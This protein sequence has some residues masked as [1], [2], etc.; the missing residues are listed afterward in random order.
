MEE[1]IKV[2]SALPV[3]HSRRINCWMCGRNKTMSVTNM[4]KYYVGHCFG[5]KE[6]ISADPPP[7]TPQQRLALQR[8]AEAF[9]ASEPELPDDFTHDI[10]IEGLLWLSKGGLHVNDIERYGFGWSDELKRTVLPVWNSDG[11]LVAVQARNTGTAHGPKYLGQV[12]SGPRPV[13]SSEL[14]SGGSRE[15]YHSSGPV[16]QERRLV[17][18]E[19]ILSA[20][21]VGK[22]NPAWSLLGTNMLPAVI[23]QIDRSPFQEVAIWMDDDEAG[24]NA[25]RKMLRQL[26]AVGI[27]ARYIA[28]DRDP[29]HHTLKEMK[30]LIH[31][32]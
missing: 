23:A 16:D 9:E 3:Q 2:A 22:V 21:R 20:A 1:W 29:K 7:M 15:T 31:A 27:P 8:A 17:L 32:V 28:S 4:G 12:W 5:C 18:T 6:K 30:E 26:G 25:R 14:R 13:W 19:D 10:P 11:A 24:I